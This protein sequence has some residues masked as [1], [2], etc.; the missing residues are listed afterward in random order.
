MPPRRRRTALWFSQHGVPVRAGADAEEILLELYDHLVET[1][2][3]GPTFYTDFPAG[4]SPLAKACGH[5]DRLAQKWDLVIGGREIATAYTELADAAELQ[6]RLAPDGDRILSSEAAA[7]G[8]GVAGG[9]RRAHAR[10]RRA[11]H[12]PGTAAAHPH[13]RHDEVMEPVVS[14][15]RRPKSR[16]PSA[17]LKQV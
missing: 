4:P 9:V 17:A 10:G 8:R 16:R 14:K 15:V 12:R 11:V 3:I 5:D 1:V 2:T 13:R 7:L 6:A